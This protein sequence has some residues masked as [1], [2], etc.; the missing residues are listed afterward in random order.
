MIATSVRRRLVTWAV[1]AVLASSLALPATGLA[2]TR[3]LPVPKGLRTV[4]VELSRVPLADLSVTDTTTQAKA[5]AQEQADFRKAA[6]AAG[7]KLTERYAYNKLFNGFSITVPAADLE[8]VAR[9]PGVQNVYPVVPMTLP[10]LHSSTEM[11]R[12]PEVVTE[13]YDGTGIKVAV[14]DTGIDYTH[15]DLGGCLGDG[16]RVAGGYD[17]VGD[18]YLGP[19]TPVIPDDDPMDQAGHGTHV[20]GIIGA[21]AASENGVTGVAPGVTFYAYKVFGPEGPTD[22]DIITAALE[23]AYEDGADVINMSLGAAFQ[24]PKYP[25]A[26]A[27]DRL[28]QRGVVVSVSAGNSGDSGLFATGAPA[29]G[30]K[31]M[32]VASF[33]NMRITVKKA[34][35]SDNDEVG[36][37]LMTFSPDPAGHTYALVAIPNLGNS[38]SDY[39]G[40]NVT[41]KAVLVS[42]GAD[43]FANKVARAARFGAAAAIIHNN[44][45]G[46]FA[47]TLGTP[48]NGD[49]DW[50]YAASTSREDGQRL[51]AKLAAGPLSITFTAEAKAIDNPTGGQVSTFS[52]WGPSPDLEIKPDLGAPGGMIYST[53]PMSQGGYASLSGT[54]MAAP[55]VAGAAALIKQADPHLRAAQ[56]QDLLRN[57]AVPRPY[58]TTPYLWPVNVQGA[59]MIDVLAAVYSPVRISPAKL[60]LGE[61]EA[62]RVATATVTLTNT[63]RRN[64]T[65]TVSHTPALSDYT[66]Y[67]NNPQVRLTD[68]AADVYIDTDQ[69]TVPAG[70][71]ATVTVEVTPPAEGDTG[72]IFSGYITF[73]NSHGI[74]TLRVPYLGYQG[75]YQEFASLDYNAYGLPWLASV[76]DGMYNYQEEMTL[77]PLTGQQA[78]V[79]VN[80]ARQSPHIRLTV[81]STRGRNMGRI[82]DLRWAGRSADPTDFFELPWDGRDARGNMIPQGDYV[83]VLEVLRPLGRESNP[84]DWETWTSGVIHIRT[85]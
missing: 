18:E 59:G 29:V 84:D 83:L 73:T 50:I 32:A 55:H 48:T 5:V 74:P 58:G 8:K 53:F 54:S 60:S 21:S 76:S 85:R 56:I 12:A 42:R 7:I 75:D 24:W 80:L 64:V 43:T 39:A 79:L 3:Q 46:F 68:L 9:L 27:A 31:V 49:A 6:K 51:R 66:T 11:I 14:I 34:T 28:V 4:F 20:A 82:Y 41:G 47:G 38:D 13:G 17:F 57:T 33:D 44:A 61:F 19:G 37:G 10:E 77:N 72:L 62:G 15:P 71:T 2:G 36:Y 26:V 69:V 23:A 78:Y 52:S 40:L 1:L 67:P 30:S 63:S 81:R 25:T 16:C 45:A 70:R 22:S 65:Y 35:L